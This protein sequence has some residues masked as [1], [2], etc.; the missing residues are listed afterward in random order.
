MQL[1]FPVNQAE[2]Q[3][4]NIGAGRELRIPNHGCLGRFSAVE[5]RPPPR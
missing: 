1:R 3:L 5:N 2:L 4:W